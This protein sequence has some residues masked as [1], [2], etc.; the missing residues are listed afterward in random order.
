MDYLFSFMKY[1][2]TCNILYLYMDFLMEVIH[3]KEL[4]ALKAKNHLELWS[5]HLYLTFIYHFNRLLI[6]EAKISPLII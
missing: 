4:T 3:S 5:L 1:K 2:V 6:A